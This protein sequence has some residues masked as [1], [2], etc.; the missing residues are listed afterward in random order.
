V[1]N[2]E[3]ETE[4]Q[5]LHYRVTMDFRMLIRPI[6]PKVCQE[7]FFFKA[8]GTPADETALQENIER[9]QAWALCEG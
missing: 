5:E 4:T 8:K 9:L 1:N 6:T 7:S 3:H 2:D